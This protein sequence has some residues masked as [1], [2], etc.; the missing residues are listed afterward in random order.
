MG[1]KSCCI[2]SLFFFVFLAMTSVQSQNRF[3]V[4][5]FRVLH[6]DFKAEMEPVSDLDG[7]Y[8]AVL[9]VETKAADKLDLEQKVYKKEIIS[10]KACYL[11]VSAREQEITFTAPGYDALTVQPPDGSFMLGKVYYTRL[12]SVIKDKPAPKAMPVLI[13]SKPTGA[14]LILNGEE[15]GHTDKAFPLDSGTYQLILM[16]E[17]YETLHKKIEISEN[18]ENIFSFSLVAL[19]SDAP[20]PMPSPQPEEP[21]RG[22]VVMWYDFESGNLDNWIKLSGEWAIAGGQLLQNSNARPAMILTGNESLENFMIEA[23]VL[24][25]SGRDG[26][27]I[28]IRSHLDSKRSLAWHIGGWSNTRTILLDFSD[29]ARNRFQKINSTDARLS[30]EQGKWYKTKIVVN[31]TNVKCY[32]NKNLIIDYTGPQ[33]VQYNSGRIGFGSYNAQ[34][35]FDNVRV[36]RLP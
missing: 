8:C 34:A 33:V 32:L 35:L 27:Y 14:R 17:G 7:N 29:M 19:E 12:K 24:F 10:D 18:K 13:G 4:Q 15:I 16:K 21:P 36:Q 2:A 28:V 3:E 11:Y 30:L 31:G 26:L 9:R 25:S 23:D 22:D 6:S 5:E 1:L 20:V